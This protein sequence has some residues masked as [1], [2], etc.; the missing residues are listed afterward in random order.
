MTHGLDLVTR[1]SGLLGQ[2]RQ[3]VEPARRRRLE[4]PPALPTAL[5]CDAVGVDRH[6]GPWIMDALPRVGC[7]FADSERWWWVV[8][9]KS[10][11]GVTWPPMARYSVGAYVAAP[12]REEREG[13]VGG[14][15][16]AGR[17]GAVPRPAVPRL[18]HWPDDTV[19]YTHPILLYIAVCRAAG[20]PPNW[21]H[22]RLGRGVPAR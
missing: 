1:L 15:G 8:P 10:Q 19:P 7:V 2:R 14:A 17:A 4:I 18:I 9:S 21:S 6:H 12:L 5:G 16:R 20:V 11:Y 22:D 13:R 3:R